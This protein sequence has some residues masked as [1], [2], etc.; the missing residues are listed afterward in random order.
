MMRHQTLLLG[1]WRRSFWVER[2]LFNIVNIGIGKSLHRSAIWWDYC[3]TTLA[4]ARVSFISLRRK[5]SLEVRRA[6]QP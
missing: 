1:E 4:G 5:P 3:W 6:A 2:P